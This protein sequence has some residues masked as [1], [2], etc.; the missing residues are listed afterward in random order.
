MQGPAPQPRDTRAVLSEGG[1]GPREAT[2]ARR[3]WAGPRT[4]QHTP[5]GSARASPVQAGFSKLLCSAENCSFHSV[6]VPKVKGKGFTGF[7]GIV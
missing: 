1:G 4:R 7:C 5:I 3:G 6:G 2:L